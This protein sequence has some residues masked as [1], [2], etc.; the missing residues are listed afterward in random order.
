MFDQ[1]FERVLD[2]KGEFFRLRRPSGYILGKHLVVGLSGSTEINVRSN[3]SGKLSS[4]RAI[5]GAISR[6]RG[7]NLGLIREGGETY[8]PSSQRFGHRKVRSQPREKNIF[9]FWCFVR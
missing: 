6:E 9:G 4:K 7:S 1:R 3:L 2:L 5:F 8:L